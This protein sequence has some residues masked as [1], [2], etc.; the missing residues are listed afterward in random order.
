MSQFVLFYTLQGVA[1]SCLTYCNH[2]SLVV[3]GCIVLQGVTC[4]LV[5][6]LY[7]VPCA[8]PNNSVYFK[9][10]LGLYLQMARINL[11]KKLIQ[12][13]KVGD[14]VW[15]THV[16]GLGVRRLKTK[17][18]FIFKTMVNKR[19]KLITIGEFGRPWTVERS[20]K[21]CHKIL[22]NIADG[23]EP[24]SGDI[25][26]DVSGLVQRYIKNY[27]LKN[28]KKGTLAAYDVYL[29]KHIVPNIGNIRAERLTQKDV[30]MMHGR[31]SDTAPIAANRTI[32]FLKAVYN[33]GIRHSLVK[34]NPVPSVTLNKEKPRER[35]LSA[36][37]FKR[38]GETLSELDNEYPLPVAAIRLLLLTGC[39]L[40]EIL[41]LRYSDI[42]FD[43]SLLN[44]ADTKTGPK[45]VVLSKPAFDI[46]CN[47]PRYSPYLFPSR[48]LDRPRS[49]LS[50]FWKTVCVQADL[51]NFKIHDLRHSFASVGVGLNVSLYIIGKLL[52]HTQS[53]TTERY[54]H[55]AV[56]PLRGAANEIAEQI[57]KSMGVTSGKT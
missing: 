35:Y 4:A 56:D 33:W 46:I 31:I 30:T 8:K 32:T 42:D 47:L 13:M 23:N 45:I 18:S 53:K 38:L 41:H 39:R 12:E 50:A 25:T 21:E 9:K 3:I 22:T 29:N 37:E 2:S 17:T 44:L 57:G 55:L 52:G 14:V 40:R 7:H 10:P 26:L 49:D 36:S 43:N 19:Q 16:R 48:R 1:P 27:G 24:H 54:A 15:D 20:R 6:N 34:A 11:T 51:N 28:C 5:S